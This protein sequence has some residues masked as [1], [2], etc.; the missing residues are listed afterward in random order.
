[1]RAREWST[2]FAIGQT[3]LIGGEI[4]GFLVVAGVHLASAPLNGRII[5]V[6]YMHCIMPP[7]PAAVV[8]GEGESSLPGEF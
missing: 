1:M 3:I 5:L 6:P 7:T 8:G 2:T 4:L